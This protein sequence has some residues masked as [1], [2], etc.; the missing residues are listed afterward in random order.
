MRRRMWVIALL[1][2]LSAGGIWAHNQ[3]YNQP[4]LSMSL[5]NAPE[6]QTQAQ[7]QAVTHAEAAIASTTVAAEPLLPS[8]SLPLA[9]LNGIYLTDDLAKIH[10]VKG[11]PQNIVQ[12]EVVK[13]S[14]TY[15]YKDC[16]IN[17]V[18]DHIQSIVVPAAVG[19]V[20]IDGTI[21]PFDQLKQR[22][23]TPFFE[24]EDGLVYRQG[25]HAFKIFS[26]T[27]ASDSPIKYVSF[28][29]VSAQ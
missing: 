23:G 26:E 21:I 29:H 24:S 4:V 16:E 25:N 20:I 5:S 1:S 2:L 22:L 11:E 6:N 19:K 13:T 28:F 18:N 8:P 14:L 15:V 10:E 27:S 3:A 7:A 17:M 9:S 12:D